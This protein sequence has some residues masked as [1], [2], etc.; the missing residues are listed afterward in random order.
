MVPKSFDLFFK[1]PTVDPADR[2]TSRG[3][4]AVPTAGINELVPE[5][6]VSDLQASLSFWCGLLG[7][8]VAYD[9]PAARFAYLVRGH[10]QIMLCERNGN[11]EVG[12]LIPPFGRG[13]NF[14]MTVIALA[15]IVTA[16]RVANWPL[17]RQE[18]D[19]WYRTGDRERGQREFLVQDPDGYLLRFAQEIG[20]RPLP[21]DHA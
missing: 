7:F 13:V 11:W 19:A 21:E 3:T 1:P 6:D 14:Q 5:L 15:P 17:F 16:L 4:G 20:T 18:N 9:R 12:E 10:I 2:G 8:E